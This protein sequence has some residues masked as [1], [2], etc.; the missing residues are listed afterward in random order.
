MGGAEDVLSELT[1]EQILQAVQ[2]DEL[3]GRQS[4]TCSAHPLLVRL[5]LGLFDRIDEVESSLG[6]KIDNLDGYVIE[7][8]A[9]NGIH[10]RY[11]EKQEEREKEAAQ[12]QR[13]EKIRNQGWWRGVASGVILIIAGVIIT[14]LIELIL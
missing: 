1:R 4:G 3:A 7:K 2:D 10:Q 9:E 14:K 8:K 11:K 5:Y 12:L 6:E 13:E